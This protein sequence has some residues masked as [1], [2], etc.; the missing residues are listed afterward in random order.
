MKSIRL[1]VFLT[2]AALCA[3]LALGAFA[4]GGSAAEDLWQT[5]F[6]AAQAKAKQEKK[7]LLVDFTGSDWCIW[8]IRLHNEVFDKEPFKAEAP[9]QFVLVELDFPHEKELSDDLKKQNKELAEKY[10]VKGFP[11]V[12]LLDAEGE[13]MAR[14]G[15]REGGA[16][17]YL[18]ELAELPK[19]YQNV[20]ACKAKL[21]KT[22]GL[23]R[24]KLLDEIVEG[25]DKL[26]I[27]SE[28][29]AEKDVTAWGKEIIALDPDN[30]AGLK[31]KYEFPPALD[32]AMKLLQTGEAAEARE[33]VDKALAWKGVPAELRQKGYMAK[34]QICLT[35]KKFVDAVAAL[36]LAKEAAPESQT[37]KRIDGFV[38][39]FSNAAEA[40]EAVDKLE[41]GLAKSEGTDR[42]KLLDKLIDAEQKLLRYDPAASRNINKWSKEIVALDPDNKAGLK[43]KYQF[44]AALADANELMGAGKLDEANA[45]L[46][47]ALEAAGISG[48]E[49][50]QAQ[51]L[52][53]G[54]AFMQDHEEQGVVHL[55]KALAAAPKGRF[56][57]AIQAKLRQHDH[58]KKPAA[59][60]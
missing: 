6:K 9:K 27:G 51:Y 38:E 28:E 2:V 59:D 26:G 32:E 34:A 36:K 12:L 49:V 18:K 24:A 31:V 14:T 10:N 55:K 13:V 30:K 7:Y 5:D 4:R 22:Q 19:I 16:E 50:Q 44:K 52:K 33:A 46:D 48:D 23:A 39:Q 1:P 40:Q 20:L 57:P 47:K 41:A 37:A 21:D 45:A 42:A 35:Q 17:E 58:A 3:A 53:A 11:T 60:E 8:C 56:V 15:Y 25:Y 29:E 43:K 54:L